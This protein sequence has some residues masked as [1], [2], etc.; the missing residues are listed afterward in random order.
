M[1]ART[2][3]RLPASARRGEVIKVRATIGHVMES[4]FR[5]G[6]DGRIVPRDIIEHFRCRYDGETV[7]EAQFSPAIAANPYLEFF[8]VA[9]VSGPL[10]FEW[11]GDH[12]FHHVE[13]VNL[14]V[15]A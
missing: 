13:T 2:L 12:G 6:P 14:A 7:F 4:G 9:T 11:A 8:T 5:T 15:T 1:T 3:I 10:T